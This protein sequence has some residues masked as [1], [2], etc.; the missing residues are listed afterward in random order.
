MCLVWRWAKFCPLSKYLNFYSSH[1]QI[2]LKRQEKNKQGKNAWKGLAR[3]LARQ[4]RPERIDQKGLV[5]K[6]L[7]RN[8]GPERIY[9]GGWAGKNWS[10][11]FDEKGWSRKTIV[12]NW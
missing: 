12:R 6:E 2:R 4:D 7:T 8:D 3:K 9:Q 1:L 11:N 10:K 5:G